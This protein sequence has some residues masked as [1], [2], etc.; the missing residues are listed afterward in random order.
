MDNRTRCGRRLRQ[1]LGSA[2]V[3]L[4][5]TPVALPVGA[6]PASAASNSEPDYAAIDSY[7]SRSLA[8]MPG[9]AIS[10]LHADQLVHAKGFGV[11]DSTGAPITADTPLFIGSQTKS[12]TALAIMQLSEKGA[13]SLDSPVQSYLPWFRVADPVHNAPM[14]LRELLNQTSGLPPSAPFDTPVTTAE[15]RA[16]DLA[17]VSLTAAPGQ[18]WQYSNSNYVILGLVIEAISGQSYAD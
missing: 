3:G 6:S 5:A 12:F 13:L 14:T 16:R 4:L 8:G 18:L 15:R 7:V 17:T 10:I 1:A 11:A 2:V 9:F